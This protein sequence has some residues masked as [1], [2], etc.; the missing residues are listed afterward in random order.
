VAIFLQERL[1]RW[2]GST[3]RWLDKAAWDRSAEPYTLADLAG[4]DCFLALDLARKLDMAAAVF[5][6][7]WPEDGPEVVRLWPVFWL[8]RQT[9]KEQ[10]HL[11]PFLTWGREG[12]PLKLTEGGTLDYGIIKDDLRGA[13]AEHRLN[14]LNLYYDEHYAN[15]LTQALHEGERL[16]P[17]AVPGVVAQRTVFGQS[18][19]YFAGPSADFER[20]VKAGMVRHPGNA[21]L[22][23]QVGHCEVWR[24]RNQNIRPVKPDFH[25]GKKIDGVVCAVMTFA[26]LAEPVPDGTISTRLLVV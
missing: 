13:I 2:V 19:M 20:R 7:P 9:A 1:N 18:L 17:T 26:G 24:D 12:G 14:V 23:W 11:F 16:G 3:Q 10:D 21:V 4:R 6:F 15:E 5:A 8:P 22:T 25:T